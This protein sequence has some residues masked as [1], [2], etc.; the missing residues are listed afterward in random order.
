MNTKPRLTEKELDAE[1]N[2]LFESQQHEMAPAQFTADVMSRIRKET[3]TVPYKAVISKQV[4]FFIAFLCG[5]LFI[6]ALFQPASSQNGIWSLASFSSLQNLGFLNTWISNL[7]SKSLNGLFASS[8]FLSL[9]GLVLAL[10]IHYI[11][12]KGFRRG[13]TNI[14][15]QMYCL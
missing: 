5:I 13:T 4:W 3:I 11:I 12:M 14:F 8:L 2:K 10:S 1:L 7:A 9:I 15:R 6:F